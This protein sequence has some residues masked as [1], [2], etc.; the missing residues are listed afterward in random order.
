MWLAS[1]S[2]KPGDKNI[3]IESLVEP[4]KII[5]PPLHIKLE[6]TEQFVKAFGFNR[7]CFKYICYTFPGLSEEKLKAGIFN[8]LEIRQLMKDLSFVASI[9]CKEGRG[10][11]ALTEVIK[12][13]LENNKAENY[14]DLPRVTVEL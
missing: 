9:T 4:E 12:N 14:K 7:D 10:W 8:G 2:L 3:I 1:K 6:L 11:K 5:L 13:F